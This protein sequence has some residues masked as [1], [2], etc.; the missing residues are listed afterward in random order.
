MDYTVYYIY[1]LCLQAFLHLILIL[2][3]HIVHIFIITLY[4]FHLYI[5]FIYCIY[6]IF[7]HYFIYLYIVLAVPSERAVISKERAA[8]SYH[9]SA[10]FLAKNLSEL[11]LILALPSIFIIFVFPIA[12]IIN[13]GS[14]FGSWFTVLFSSFTL[15]VCACIHTLDVHVLVDTWYV[16]TYT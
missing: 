13:P 7:A 8:G 12:G 6:T 5:V 11:P 1:I 2:F 9:L 10:Y 4:L 15:Q 14:F 3:T 16:Y